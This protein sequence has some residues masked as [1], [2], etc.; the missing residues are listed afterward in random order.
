MTET[1]GAP[2][3]HP[4]FDRADRAF[5]DRDVFDV[6]PEL[7]GCLLERTD[8]RG[9][10]TLR[11]TEVEAYAGADDPGAHSY[12]GRTA[13]NATMFGPAGHVYCYFT[14]GLHHAVNVVTR[15][16]GHGCLVRA[17]EIVG[18]A[19]LA[20]ERRERPASAAPLP[21]WRL[22]RGPGT[23]AQAFGATLADDGADLVETPS[24][25]PGWRFFAPV[26][27]TGH[28]TSTGP[29]VGVSGPAGDGAAYPW[30]YWI[31][32]DPT[33]SAYRPGAK[34][35]A[36]RVSRGGGGSGSAPAP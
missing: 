6:A 24:S 29:R 5:F 21:S 34:S 18:G 17:G 35:R 9:T 2:H 11:I 7:L 10:V 30:R 19:D 32:G 13:R 26:V 36:G 31:V 23:V 8:A 22:A 1:R 27:A 28:P 4:G 15:D 20:R 16:D 3:G 33:V 14:Y 12:R 25:G